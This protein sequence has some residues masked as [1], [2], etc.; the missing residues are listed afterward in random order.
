M[1]IVKRVPFTVTLVLEELWLAVKSLTTFSI[2]LNT[3]HRIQYEKYTFIIILLPDKL[4][5]Q[6]QTQTKNDALMKELN[7]I[8]IIM[9]N[10]IIL[11]KRE[12]EKVIETKK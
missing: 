3:K 2:S 12:Q 10:R 7:K 1:N 5:N 11:E 6:T 9:E 8:T 4:L